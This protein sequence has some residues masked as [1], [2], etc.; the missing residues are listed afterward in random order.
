MPVDTSMSVDT[1]SIDLGDEERDIQERTVLIEPTPSV[2]AWYRLCKDDLPEGVSVADLRT[3]LTI[4]G[5]VNALANSDSPKEC[6][7]FNEDEDSIEVPRFFGLSLSGIPE[8]DNRVYGEVREE[9]MMFNG[10]L[11]PERKQPEAVSKIVQNLSDSRKGMGG[12]L[13]LPCGM[14]KTCVA[15]FVACHF[16]VRTLIIVPTTVLAA[17]WVER[18]TYFCPRSTVYMMKGSHPRGSLD[19]QDFDFAVA[20][21]QTM[22]LCEIDLDIQRRFGLTIVDEA[23]G[24]C[25]PTFSKAS[26]KIRSARVLAL[27]ATPE[28]P[29]GLHEGMPHLVGPILF[30]TKRPNLSIKPTV[31]VLR[32]KTSDLTEQSYEKRGTKKLL[33]ARMVNQIASHVG[34]TQ[35]LCDRIKAFVDEGR[36]ILVLSERLNL[37]RQVQQNFPPHVCGLLTGAVSQSKRA[38]EMQ[39]SL[40]LATY[41]LC[42]EGFD[43]PNLNTL[44]MATPVTNIE[45]SVGRILRGG[46]SQKPPLILDLSDTYSIFPAY[47]KKRLRFYNK[48]GFMVR[49]ESVSS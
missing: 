22:S 10:A 34:R 29:D 49:Q 33:I 37:L 12:V 26:Q 1:K 8:H 48:N 42:R 6:M 39:K 15:L 24:L 17:Q 30:R 38:E 18:I 7:L 5:K 11:D 20:T 9:T 45:Q 21:I 19:D 16:K 2:S 31:T 43:K 28:R 14:G 46:A 4:V 23:H 3:Q 35:I 47:Y 13:V 36:Q 27:S 25:A 41:G 44:V 40:I 32:I